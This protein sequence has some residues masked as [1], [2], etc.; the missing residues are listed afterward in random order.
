MSNLS[1][2]HDFTWSLT[3]LGRPNFNHDHQDHNPKTELWHVSCV[4]ICYKYIKIKLST[5]KCHALF[6]PIIQSKTVHWF[7][8]QCHPSTSL[9]WCPFSSLV[10]TPKLVHHLW[11]ELI[12]F[13]HLLSNKPRLIIRTCAPLLPDKR[14]ILPYVFEEMWVSNFLV[15]S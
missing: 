3:L 8:G 12:I 15:S 1:L 5:K 4:R 11:T 13:T 2:F 9:P 6:N 10:S 14:N 7:L